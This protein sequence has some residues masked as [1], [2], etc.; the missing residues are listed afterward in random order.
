MLEATH[1]ESG[2]MFGLNGQIPVASKPLMGLAIVAALMKAQLSN[3]LIGTLIKFPM[4][5]VIWNIV[6]TLPGFD[7]GQFVNS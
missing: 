2:K 3:G 5:S 4:V 7:L 1:S 6:T